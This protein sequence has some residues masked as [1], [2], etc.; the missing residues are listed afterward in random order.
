MKKL[1]LERLLERMP[2]G[3]MLDIHEELS[4]GIVPATGFAHSFCRSVNRMIDAGKMCIS[5]TTYRKVYLPT[6]S[7]AMNAEMARRHGYYLKGYK[8]YKR[9]VSVAKGD[10][11]EDVQL[12]VDTIL[13]QCAKEE[14]SNA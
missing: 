2:D 6:L 10:M 8:P 9:T 11:G 1:T 13:E 5:P 14:R 12:T 7:K 3:N 4:S